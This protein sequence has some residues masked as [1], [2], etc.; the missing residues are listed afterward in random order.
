MLSACK[1]HRWHTGCRVA[2]ERRRVQEDV[3]ERRRERIEDDD[4]KLVGQFW[5]DIRL[6]QEKERKEDKVRRER[7]RRILHELM[8]Q[9]F[10][11]T[12]PKHH[13]PY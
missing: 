3:V 8:G 11:D 1:T 4:W 2:M 7:E 5:H 9:K 12:L 13:H 10:K 6:K